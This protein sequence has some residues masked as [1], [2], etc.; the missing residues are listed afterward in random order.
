MASDR[1]SLGAFKNLISQADLIL[2]TTPPMPENCTGACREVLRSARPHGRYA[3]VGV[4]DT[5]DECLQ[6]RVG[7]LVGR[8]LPALRV[9]QLLPRPQTLRVTPAMESK[10]AD[11]VSEIVELLA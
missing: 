9:L 4:P 10:L 5:V 7:G 2:E 1:S 6:P 3:E 11:H 8:V